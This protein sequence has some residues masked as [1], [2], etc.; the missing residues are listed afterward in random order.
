MKKTVPYV[1]ATVIGFYAGF[2]T[3]A[4]HQYKIVREKGQAYLYD[5]KN[6]K[7]E[8]IT[9]NFQLGNLE[10]R[11][12]GIKKEIGIIKVRETDEYRDNNY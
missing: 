11:I 7:K 5:K 12:E 3:N 8:P 1:V 4:D 9:D 10:Y 2:Y 6:Q